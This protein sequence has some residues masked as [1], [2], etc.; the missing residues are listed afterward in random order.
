MLGRA[1]LVGGEA[2]VARLLVEQGLQVGLVDGR[3]GAE[4]H[5]VRGV[6][7]LGIVVGVGAGGGPGDAR[8][9]LV[10][11]G[12]D[13]VP[14]LRIGRGGAAAQQGFDAGN[15][16]LRDL[17]GRVEGLGGV[18]GGGVMKDVHVGLLG[19]GERFYRCCG[20]ALDQG[21]KVAAPE[22]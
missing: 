20:Q 19:V 8:L 7:D 9:A 13:K 10:G 4:Y 2:A 15:L 21:L 1:R 17:P 3:A 16:V 12:E 11:G 14:G 18:T 5:H 6:A 22:L